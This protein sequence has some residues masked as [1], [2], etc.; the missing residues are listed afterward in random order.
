ME[1]A[2]ILYVD[3]TLL[4]HTILD[5]L[6]LYLTGRLCFLRT[7][8]I[9]LTAASIAGGIY[10]TVCMIDPFGWE[11]SETVR[12]FF[13]LLLLYIAFRPPYA[14]DWGNGIL[15]FYLLNLLLTG[16]VFFVASSGILR[17]LL[18][19]GLAAGSLYFF[20]CQLLRFF[21]RISHR[22]TKADIEIHL[23]G[24][25]ISSAAFIDT[26]NS[27]V[28]PLGKKPVIVLARQNF[29]FLEGELNAENIV[30]KLN[31]QD[32]LT[33]RLRLVPYCSVGKKRGMLV[34]FQ[35][36]EVIIRNCL[37]TGRHSQIVVAIASEEIPD[38]LIPAALL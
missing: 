19:W 28:D 36:D 15:V 18:L 22:L 13:P 4:L 16:V 27:L 37:K 3:M 25:V 38:C 8:K 35:T 32:L 21:P 20:S 34:G 9:R 1:E 12:I 11:A 10:G 31:G 29:P 5:F 30:E 33:Q 7:G 2:P 14:R 17:P 26:G 6:L 24:T 23:N